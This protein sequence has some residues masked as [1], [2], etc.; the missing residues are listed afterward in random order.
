VPE[1][2]CLLQLLRIELPPLG[3][4]NTPSTRQ[5]SWPA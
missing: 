5:G 3:A 1:L 4:A 2:H